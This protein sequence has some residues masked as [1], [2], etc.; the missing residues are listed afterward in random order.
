METRPPPP[1]NMRHRQQRSPTLASKPAHRRVVERE[2]LGN[3]VRGE[4]S[5]GNAD[6]FGGFGFAAQER[7]R[8]A[9]FVGRRLRLAN[10]DKNEG[11]P[12][13]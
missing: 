7:E 1:P 11:R 2:G 6:G 9:V 12:K 4:L 13:E 10:C 8:D 3:S 5:G